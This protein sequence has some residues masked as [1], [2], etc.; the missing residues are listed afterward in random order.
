MDKTMKESN[1]KLLELDWIVR[2]WT[3]KQ[4]AIHGCVWYFILKVVIN[5]AYNSEDNVE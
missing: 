2:W 3:A 4:I 5:Y 1:K